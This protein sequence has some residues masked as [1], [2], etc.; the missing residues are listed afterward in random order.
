MPVAQL[1]F[2]TLANWLVPVVLVVA[3]N[4]LRQIGADLK[5]ISG[6]LKTIAVEVARLQVRVGTLEGS[7][8]E[9]ERE[10]S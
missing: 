5:S 2:S 4:S 3:V 1:D 8:C 7:P 9:D 10:Y 6:E